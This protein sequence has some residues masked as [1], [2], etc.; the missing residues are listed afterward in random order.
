MCSNFQQMLATRMDMF[1]VGF[2]FIEA[3]TIL[4]QDTGKCS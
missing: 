2:K 3:D 1:L 4:Q